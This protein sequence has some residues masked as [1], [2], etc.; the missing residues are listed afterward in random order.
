MLSRTYSRRVDRVQAAVDAL[1]LPPAVYRTC[2][3]EP[4]EL[5]ETGLRQWLR[6]CGA[7]MLDRQVI[8]MPSFAVDEAWHGLILCTERYAAFCRRA[9]GRFLHHHPQGGEL[10]GSARRAGSMAEQLRR[11]AVAWSFVARPGEECV[12]WD[13]DVRV[14]VPEPWGAGTRP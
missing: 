10:A 1:E 2:P 3:F 5:V 12:L 13:L 4:R 11:T 9:Y 14:G 7:A 6:C 8:G